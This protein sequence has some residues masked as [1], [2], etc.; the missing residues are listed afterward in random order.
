M[1]TKLISIIIATYNASSTIE[2]CLNSII[3]QKNN[4]I[5]LLIVDGKSKDNT[6]DIIKKY[7]KDIDFFI[8][9]PDKG[10]YDAW[11]KGITHTNGKWIMFI[12]ADDIILPK[13]L[14][15]YL[16]YLQNNNVNDLDLIS[17]RC[18]MINKQG[19]KNH[20]LG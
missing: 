9:E 6:T 14:N 11:N 4:Q 1:N 18:E 10:I 8:S 15:K 3:Q 19:K 7:I 17:A 2:R 20:Y 12:G 16:C 13:S 5:E